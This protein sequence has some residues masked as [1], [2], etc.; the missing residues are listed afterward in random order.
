MDQLDRHFSEVLQELRVSQTGV[1]I[2]FAFLLTLA[3]SARFE[4]ISDFG[5]DVYVVTLLSTA[6]ATACF[7]APVPY[8]R[9]VFRKG[10]R[11][12]LVNAANWYARAGLVFLLISIGG[13]ILLVTHVVLGNVWAG[14]LTA[15]V[16]TINVTLW[17]V[18]PLWRRSRLTGDPDGARA[19]AGLHTEL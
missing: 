16:V 12:D 4:D 2:L 19:G 7:I 5:R 3:F 11:S 18:I 15:L 6:A 13:S 8:H 17:Y 14:W 9:I 10:L 1:Q